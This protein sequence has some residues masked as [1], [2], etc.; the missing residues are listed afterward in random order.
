MHVARDRHQTIELESALDTE[1]TRERSRLKR[2]VLLNRGIGARHWKDNLEENVFNLIYD[3]KTETKAKAKLW[4]PKNTLNFT[5]TL[6][7]AKLLCFQK[8]RQETK[9]DVV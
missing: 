6:Q 7:I 9:N 2:T 1:N 4:H 8:F 5:Q 3:F